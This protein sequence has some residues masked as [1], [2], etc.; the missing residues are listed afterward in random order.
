[1]PLLPPPLS[2][3][4]PG[5]LLQRNQLPTA[6]FLLQPDQHLD[7]SSILFRR[8]LLSAAG[9]VLRREPLWMCGL[10]FGRDHLCQTSLLLRRY[11]CSC[12][13]T[14]RTG[15][16]APPVTLHDAT[17]HAHKNKKQVSPFLN[18]LNFCQ[19]F[20]SKSNLEIKLKRHNCVIVF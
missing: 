11:P 12:G 17:L 19:I 10:N 15:L 13:V 18:R 3:P 4:P 20:N 7:P 14:T 9:L 2:E 5:P 1:M 8:D 6:G 16:R